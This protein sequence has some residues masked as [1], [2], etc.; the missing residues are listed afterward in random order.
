MLCCI[1]LKITAVYQ[2]TFREI[3]II[4]YGLTSAKYLSRCVTS[5]GDWTRR[6]FSL[7]LLKLGHML[8][9]FAE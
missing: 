7:H 3:L 4:S 1:V 9:Y 8:K 6:L 2:T 5:A